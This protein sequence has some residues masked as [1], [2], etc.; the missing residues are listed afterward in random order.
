LDKLLS[1]ETGL[2]VRVADDPLLCVALGGG[3]F[4]ETASERQLELLEHD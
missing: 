2:K 4:L 1:E 3:K